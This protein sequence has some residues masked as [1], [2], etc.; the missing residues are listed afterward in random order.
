MPN[1]KIKKYM[2]ILIKYYLRNC[3][4]NIDFKAVL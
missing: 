3:V 1:R 2:L 4:M